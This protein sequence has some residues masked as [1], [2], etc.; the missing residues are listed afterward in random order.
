VTAADASFEVDSLHF[1]YW[2]EDKVTALPR[3]R[4]GWPR[5]RGVAA[6]NA[7]RGGSRSQRT[8]AALAAAAPV[9]RE[10]AQQ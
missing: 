10:P 6:R 2:Q 1:R 9:L 5:H 4:P 8:R 7:E 3:A